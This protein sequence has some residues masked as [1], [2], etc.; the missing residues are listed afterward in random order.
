VKG[1]PPGIRQDGPDVLLTL[2]VHP[3]A[4]R[5]QLVFQPPDR[6]LLRLSAPPVGGAANAACC[7]FLADL[8]DL[9]KSRLTIVRGESSRHKQVRI[10]NADLTQILA[11]LHSG[12]KNLS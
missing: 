9:P 7:T 2:V 6:W 5:N 10:W 8:L 3:R 4:A 1:D 12:K 11:R